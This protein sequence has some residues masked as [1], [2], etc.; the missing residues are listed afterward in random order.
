MREARII[1]PLY[2]NEGASLADTHTELEGKLIEHFGGCTKVRGTGFDMSR[3]EVVIESV[4]VYDVAMTMGLENRSILAGLAEWLLFAADQRSVYLR[5]PDG[6]VI[7][8][9]GNKP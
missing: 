3:G 1:C 9:E 8:Y 6:E 7:I 4:F 5:Y 2:D